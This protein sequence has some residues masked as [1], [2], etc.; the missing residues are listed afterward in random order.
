MEFHEGETIIHKARPHW[1]VFGWALWLIYLSVSFV[2]S[3]NHSTSQQATQT[4]LILAGMFVFY[5]MVA[6]C[7][8]QL[9]RWSSR[10][11]LTSR[12][13]ILKNGI[14]RQRS[15]EFLVHT[16]ESVL[17]ELAVAGRLFNYGTVTVR[18]FGG[19]RGTMKRLPK[20]ERVR[21]LIQEQQ[22]LDRGASRTW[23]NVS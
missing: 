23:H 6:A 14:L 8:A 11:T 18:G 10:L 20:P 16:V 9:Y 1:I 15:S 22:S 5:A 21:E 2:W 19:S 13:V 4:W 7:I 3:A 12:R 17:V